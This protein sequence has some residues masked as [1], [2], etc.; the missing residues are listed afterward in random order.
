VG[1]RRPRGGTRHRAPDHHRKLRRATEIR[2]L[3]AARPIDGFPGPAPRLRLYE[4]R[5]QPGPAVLHACCSPNTRNRRALASVPRYAC[6]EWE[7]GLALHLQLH[8]PRGARSDRSGRQERMISAG[9]SVTSS[10]DL[11]VDFQPVERVVQI[12]PPPRTCAA[13]AAGRPLPPTAPGAPPRCCHAPPNALSLLELSA[14]RWGGLDAGWVGNVRVR[15]VGPA[16][17]VC[18]STSTAW[19]GGSGV[20]ARQELEGRCAR[21]SFRHLDDASWQWCPAFFPRA[22]RRCLG[23][24]PRYRK[25][26]READR[27]TAA[28]I[29]ASIPTPPRPAPQASPRRFRYRSAT[30]PSAPPATGL[31]I[32]SDH[33]RS[34]GHGESGA[35][36]SLGMWRSRSWPG[37]S[38][39]CLF[40]RPA[41]QPGVR[42]ACVR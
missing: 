35:R 42:C 29:P 37:S 28:V 34:F 11:G 32:G 9:W 12:G 14:L 38:R 30:T 13:A 31:N 3:L 40:L 1:A 8:R 39:G 6:P 33:G 20:R 26:E 19:P 17:C 10:L 15:P 18:C 16:R 21:W 24:Y 22:G 36:A 27:S 2:S 4:E 7:D 23:A 25:L 5:G 41:A